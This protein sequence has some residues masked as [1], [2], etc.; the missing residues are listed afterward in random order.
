MSHLTFTG[1]LYF[2]V[3]SLFASTEAKL[4]VQAVALGKMW[5]VEA[6]ALQKLSSFYQ[7]RMDS[8][9]LPA[10]NLPLLTF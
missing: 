9:G 6:A 2:H 1:T 8:Q 7:S 10:W 5:E 4:G 3:H